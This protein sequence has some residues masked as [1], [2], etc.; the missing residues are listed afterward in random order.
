[1]Q[2]PEIDA[3]ARYAMLIAA[4]IMAVQAGDADTAVRAIDTMHQSF[5][6]DAWA[7]KESVFRALIKKTLDNETRWKLANRLV[8]VAE[9]AVQ[10]QRFKTAIKLLKL[11]RETAL[12]SRQL[13]LAKGIA[14]R[15]E[16]LNKESVRLAE[17]QRA[18]HV[19]GGDD[20]NAKANEIAGRYY[21]FAQGDWTRGL[22][23]LAKSANE[24]LAAA[25]VQDLRAA[26]NA[27]EQ[28]E[29]GDTWWA[30]FE[31]Q[32]AESSQPALV[33][34][35]HWYSAALPNVSGLQKRKCE[36]RL[37]DAAIAMAKAT[38]QPAIRTSNAVHGLEFAGDAWLE[39]ALTYDGKSALT[40]E[41]WVTPLATDQSQS[42][43]ANCHGLGLAL[44][45]T[46][47][48]HW[49]FHVR[50]L[51]AYQGAVSNEVAKLGQRVH[52]AGVFDGRQI[53]LFVSGHRQDAVGIMTSR[54]KVSNLRFMIGADPDFNSKPQAFFRGRIDSV[55]VSRAAL[56]DKD[57]TPSDPPKRNRSTALLLPLDEG[58]GDVAKDS[59]LYQHA[60][61]IHGAKWK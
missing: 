31:Q 34:A 46:K 30:I 3:N 14:V 18:L 61:K 35:R 53:R 27:A 21:C 13:P 51:K 19:L 26:T 20:A 12:R 8:G 15:L 45:V 29:L 2:D 32:E 42:I 16:E 28:L 38:D 4:R 60:V 39:T 49:G 22:P 10:Q 6:V 25:A 44:Q 5:D 57:F 7:I 17:F 33:R 23:L 40:I 37:G 55:H 54:H 1:M 9:K 58:E 56:Y 41:T 11:A 48:G 50:D 52:V 36:K 43:V 47:D 59:S 24:T